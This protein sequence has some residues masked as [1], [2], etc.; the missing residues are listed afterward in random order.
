MSL[1]TLKHLLNDCSL[2]MSRTQCAANKKRETLEDIWRAFND[3]IE[4]RFSVGKVSLRCCIS[5][6]RSTFTPHSCV[7]A[8]QGVHIATFATITWETCT[9]ARNQAKLRPLL[10]LSDTFIKTYGLQQ[11]KPLVAPVMASCEDIN[12]TK[13]AIKFSKN[14][15]KDLVFCGIR[16]LLQKIGEVAATGSSVSIVF[17]IGRLIAKNRCVSMIFDPL[18]FPRALEDQITRSMLGSPRSAL[19]N[20]ADF[21][22]S[23]EDAVSYSNEPSRDEAISMSYGTLDVVEDALPT[24]RSNPENVIGFDMSL[25]EELQQF[26][27]L[28]SPM[29]EPPNPVM[30]SAFKRHIANLAHDVDR[31][32]RY[33]T[34]EQTQQKRDMETIALEQ[35][36]RRLCAEDLQRHLKMQMTERREL[37]HQGK[38]EQ[39][40]TEPSANSF[41]CDSELTRLGYE[42]KEYLQQLTDEL[43]SQLK[44]QISAKE[45]ERMNERHKH[46]QDDKQFLRR[47]RTELD[48]IEYKQRHDRDEQRQVLTSAWQRD[49]VMKKMVVAKK[50]QRVVE[51]LQHEGGNSGS[52][53]KVDY[54][55]NLPQPRT[56]TPRITDFS[57]GFDIRS[58][59][60][61]T[62]TRRKT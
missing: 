6:C 10:L 42:D 18:K 11:K 30:E 50:Q 48:A 35:R 24:S 5:S 40:N 43:K 59:G 21:E 37:K 3:W 41:Y 28:Y 62:Q 38:Q 13:I 34:D 45:Q 8:L 31:E 49:S 51:Q 56:P 60:K 19:G 29:N 9:N 58:V 4:S 23:P 32:V 36:M 26:D 46:L 47:L 20:L 16:D 12:F 61:Q 22:I 44:D 27:G 33:A 7:A 1:Y 39:K 55:P 25:E 54:L 53:P 15:T 52:P 14:L 57:V 17:T 2:R